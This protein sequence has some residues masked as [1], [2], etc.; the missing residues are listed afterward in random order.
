MRCRVEKP[1]KLPGSSAESVLVREGPAGRTSSRRSGEE[2]VTCTGNE[3]ISRIVELAIA[4]ATAMSA[5]GH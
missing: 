3:R 4:F 5:L 1:A 2:G